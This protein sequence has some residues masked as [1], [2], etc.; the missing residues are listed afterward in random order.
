M[1]WIALYHQWYRAQRPSPSIAHAICD[2]VCERRADDCHLMTR[3]TALRRVACGVR[4]KVCHRCAG[5][6]LLI[7]FAGGAYRTS[8]AADGAALHVARG[9]V[10]VIC[11]LTVGG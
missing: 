5:A 2:A 6:T 7:V 11:P 3:G 1:P 8:V 10:R 9:D 4:R